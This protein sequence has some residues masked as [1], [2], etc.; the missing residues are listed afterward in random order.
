IRSVPGNNISLGD[1]L[2]SSDV[3]SFMRSRNIEIVGKGLKPHTRLYGFFG[4]S[5]VTKYC[6]PKLLEIEMISGTFIVGETVVSGGEFS[7][8]PGVNQDLPYISFRV[9]DSHHRS[10]PFNDPQDVYTVNPYTREEMPDLY[11]TTSTILNVDL[12]SMALAPTGDY[13]G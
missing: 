11:S 2:V 1:K 10:G 12:A 7:R 8:R 9:A 6:V 4:A 13:F 3:S 5:S